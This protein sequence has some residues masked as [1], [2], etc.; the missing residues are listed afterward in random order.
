MSVGKGN[1]FGQNASGSCLANDQGIDQ[2]LVRAT[3]F[4]RLSAEHANAAAQFNLGIC[5]AAGRSGGI[6]L[7]H[8]LEYYSRGAAQG[9]SSGHAALGR[10]LVEGDGVEADPVRGA[11][12]ARQAADERGVWAEFTQRAVSSGVC[13]V[14]RMWARLPFTTNGGAYIP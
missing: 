7:H 14:R 10:C 12:L 5:L 11:A 2:D 3:D 13:E 6:I 8:A 4:S 9:D 1:A